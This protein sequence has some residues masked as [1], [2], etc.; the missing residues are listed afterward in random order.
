MRRAA[1]Q[2]PL[3]G[4]PWPLDVAKSRTCASHA[5]G[6]PPRWSSPSS[7]CSS[8]S[9]A[10]PRPRSASSTAACCARTASPAAR[11]R[12][13]SVAKADLT[14]G[15]VR[16]LMATPA[17]SV[18]SA[19]IVD[20]QVLAPDLGAGS[21]GQ[22]Q[23]AAGAVTASK[24][25]PD[26]VGGGSVANG[27]LQTV[28]IGSFT[29]CGASDD[30]DPST[31]QQRCQVAAAP[32]MP[33]G[34]Q[35]NIADDVVVVTAARAWS[36]F[37]HRHRQARRRTTSIRIVACWT[38]DAGAPPTARPDALSLRD[39][40]RALRQSAGSYRLHTKLPGGSEQGPP[41]SSACSSPPHSPV[42]ERLRIVRRRITAAVLATFVA[43]WLAVAALGKGGATSTTTTTSAVAVNRDVEPER[44]RPRTAP[45]R[46]TT[47]G[48]AM[49]RTLRR[50]ATPGRAATPRR[51]RAR[52]PLP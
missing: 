2:H 9:A 20:G 49:A 48:A 42:N 29:G 41:R 33:A 50:A 36:D 1:P 14:K 45:R 27:S 11:S 24:L 37:H 23:L 34:G 17:R 22:T 5:A 40:R 31:S 46:A 52:R 4:D 3:S 30:F 6:R 38:G 43:A 32:A 10:P 7:P 26:S 51:A 19:Q 35:P 47:T 21:V 8:R 25:A 28:D 15:A 12:T 39:V 44:R 13:A 18:R 16:S